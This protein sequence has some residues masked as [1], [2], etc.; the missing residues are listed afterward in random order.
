MLLCLIKFC[1]DSWLWIVAERNII[2]DLLQQRLVKLFFLQY[3]TPKCLPKQFFNCNSLY[4]NI[5]H[6]TIIRMEIFPIKQQSATKA[7]TNQNVCFKSVL[8]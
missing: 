5:T 2:Y 6:K 3:Y 4:E 8:L 7:L 1:I